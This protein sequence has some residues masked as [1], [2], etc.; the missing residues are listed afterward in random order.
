M[1]RRLATLSLALALVAGSVTPA[2]A[3][4]MYEAPV[5]SAMDRIAS[6]RSLLESGKLDDAASYARS[7]ARD[8]RADKKVRAEAY[9]IA[10]VIRWKQGNKTAAKTNFK[11]ALEL[12]PVQYETVVAKQSDAVEIR[13]VVDEA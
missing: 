6:A 4:G 12:D 13:A 5:E 3:C 1:T 10:G 8:R 2:A 7:V 11:R 9:S